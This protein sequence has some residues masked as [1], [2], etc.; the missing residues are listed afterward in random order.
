MQING[1]TIRRVT[2]EV[3]A[4]FSQR[5]SI[6]SEAVLN[7]VTKRLGVFHDQ[8]IDHALLTFW[9]DLFR[10]GYLS[11]GLNLNNPNPPW[12]HLTDQGRVA[13]ATISRDPAN[14]DGYLAHLNSRA[15]LN[16]IAL[17]YIREALATF[18]AQ[19]FKAAAV[20]VGVASESLVLEL[21]DSLVA[22]IRTL[23]QSPPPDL[24]D[25]R[26]KRVLNAIET[27]ILPRTRA[28]PQVL[29]QA[30]DANWSAFIH[31]IR[32]ARNEAG[33][34]AAID[35]VTSDGVH[36]SLLIFPELAKLAA[37]LQEWVTSNYV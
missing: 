23:N 16:P 32:A 34:P 21:R 30:Y 9:Y 4:E 20:M 12:C 35:P 13:L 8:R 14:P 29:A 28:M 33:H 2:L 18:N 1:E 15:S 25:W 37:D 22:R 7:E 5:D 27:L 11:W 36:A 10:S 24:E 26:I 3:V 19:C 17:S 31:Q 6:H